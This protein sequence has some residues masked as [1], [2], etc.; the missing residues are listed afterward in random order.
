[1]MGRYGVADPGPELLESGWALEGTR[2]TRAE[3]ESGRGERGAR[4]RLG[5]ERSP[6]PA[7]AREEPES[8]WG[9]RGARSA[10]VEPESGWG[11]RGEQR[12]PR[13]V[14][15]A[16]SARAE[17]SERGE[18][19]RSEALRMIRHSGSSSAERA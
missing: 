11:A 12:S 14:E 18:S 1:L 2:S 15:G 16:R 5:R 13:R 10:R 19:R 17:P 8:G 3:P 7:G 9:A 4:I 6:N